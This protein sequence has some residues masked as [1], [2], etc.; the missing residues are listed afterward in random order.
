MSKH[1]VKDEARREAIPSSVRSTKI[2]LTGGLLKLEAKALSYEKQI[3]SSSFERKRESEIG[4]KE[5]GEEGLLVLGMGK[6]E[7]F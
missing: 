6:T 1:D 3:Y 2:R 7:C 5:E 4:R